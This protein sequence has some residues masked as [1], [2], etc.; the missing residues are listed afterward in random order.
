[1]MR[2]LGVLAIVVPLLAIG[3]CQCAPA[4]APRTTYFVEQLYDGNLLLPG[5]RD[6]G[7]W[8]AKSRRAVRPDFIGFFAGQGISVDAWKGWG[9]GRA[10][11]S[12]TFNDHGT[13]V[14]AS[15]V[16]TNVR[17]CGGKWMY[18][19]LEMSYSGTVPAS[20]SPY[21]PRVERITSC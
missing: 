8:T 13:T 1:M 20:I 6:D 21:V 5:M 10:V 14:R 15:A 16:L 17:K 12:G 11:G 9:T 7:T 4:P 18:T 2:R 19:R 3:G